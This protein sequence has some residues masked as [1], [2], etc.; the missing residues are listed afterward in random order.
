MAAPKL[1]ALIVQHEE[2]TPPGFLGEWLDEHGA[3]VDILRIDREQTIPDPRDYQLIASLGSEFAA[4]DDSVP[5]I[6]RE[7]E[8]IKQAAEHDV[9]VLG[10]CFG[11]QLLARV[12]GG[13]SFRAERSEIGWLPVRTKDPDLIPEGPWFQWHF[14]SFTLPPGAK[15]LADTE[16]GPQAYVVGRSLGLQFHPEVTPQIMDSWVRAY[17]HELDGDGVD[18]DA[19]LEETNRRAPDVRRRSMR[20]FDRFLEK[21]ARVGSGAARGR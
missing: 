4:F 10:L 19:L 5:F 7:T 17:R 16:V 6:P 14:D 12:L 9:P 2:P 3:D 1:K 8:L 20:L 11:G 13:N 18:P 15:L 21:I